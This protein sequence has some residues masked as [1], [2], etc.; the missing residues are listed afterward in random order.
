MREV[1]EAL[2][3]RLAGADALRDAGRI[4]EAIVEYLAIV[5]AAPDSAQAHYKLGTGYGKQPGYLQDAEHCYRKSLAI[6]RNYPEANHNLGL[7]LATRCEYDEAEERYLAAL[8][9]RPD[10]ASVHHRLGRVLLE[11]GQVDRARYHGM[12]V[13]VL[14]PDWG[15]G[16]DL[17][18]QV[19]R[20]QGRITEAIAMSRRAVDIESNSAAAWVNLGTCLSSCGRHDE[21]EAALR[22]ALEISPGFFPAWNNLLLSANYRLHDRAE[23]FDLHRAYGQVVRERCGNHAVT[24]VHASPERRLRIGIL[25]GDLRHHSVAYFLRGPLEVLD[26]RRFELYAYYNQRIDDEISRKLRPFFHCWRSVHGLDDEAAAELIRRDRID[27]L[28]DLAGHTATARPLVLGRKPAPVQLHWIG[29]PNTTG[30]DSVD[31]RITDE[32]ADPEAEAGCYS[33][34]RLWRLPASFLCYSPPESAPEPV[35]PP[36]L[37]RGYV[38]FGSFNVRAKLSDECIAIWCE[39]LRAQ[40]DARLVVKSYLGAG[41]DEA[42][43]DLQHVFTSRGIASERIIVL[44]K[45]ESTADHLSAYG[46]VD[47]ALDT[48]PYNGTTTTCEA[49]WMGVPVVTL[50]GD[51]HA[52]R[53]G[54]SLLNNAGLGD[55]VARTGEDFVAIAIELASDPQRLGSLRRAMRQHLVGSRLFDKKSMGG[56]LGDALRGMWREYCAALPEEASALCPDSS[57]D[58]ELI[59]LH[60][61]GHEKRDGWKILDIEARP[62]VDFVGDIANLDAFAD[63]SCSEIYC[64]HVLVRV[65]QAQIFGTI[66]G[67]YRI[68][69]PGGRLYVSVPDLETLAWLFLNP[70]HDATARFQVMRRMFGAQSDEHDFHKVGLYFELMQAYLRDAGFSAI[71]HVQTFDLFDDTSTR[72]FDGNLISLNL[73]ATK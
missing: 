72:T 29:Y 4:D 37:Q 18:G 63:E 65:S 27:I 59:K 15:D 34:E 50:S 35:D 44:E 7:M 56:D 31:Y 47:I 6:W 1:P 33:V 48:F 14:R 69:A 5:A 66:G 40:P 25:S 30:L 45:R 57:R 60:V 41:D 49:L 19:A 70:G 9:E 36:C 43:E 54:A 61:G 2:R 17:V 11:T 12:R 39:V 3:A 67:L 13:Q 28:I 64:S 73:I 8:A 21:A 32:W 46:E 23:V 71:E 52:A 10:F 58:R 16:Y 22:R 53:V 38:T 42:R 51:R 26:R 68:L 55:L 62:E 20:A 24:E